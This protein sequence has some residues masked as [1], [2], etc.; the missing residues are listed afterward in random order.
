MNDS[1]YKKRFAAF[2]HVDEEKIHVLPAFIAP[3]ETER[4]GLPP[5]VIDFKNKHDFLISGNAF[6]LILEN[7]KD[8]YGLDLLINLV[9][10]MRDEGVNAGLL[11]CL[12]CIGDD[13]YYNQMKYLIEKLGLQ[14]HIMIVNKNIDNAF[15]YWELS[16]LFIRPTTTDMEGISVKEALYM[17]THVIASDVCKRPEECVLFESRNQEDLNRKAMK[18]YQSQRYKERVNYSSMTDTPKEMLKIYQSI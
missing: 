1:D 11:F 14:E 5:E 9:K 2:F 12:P 13:E 18:L 6:K 16:H 3:R 4:H 15:E 8:I 17:G 7:G 10:S